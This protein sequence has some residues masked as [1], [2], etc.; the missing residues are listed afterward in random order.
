MLATLS[1]LL[2]T[3]V[4]SH[5]EGDFPF[6]KELEMGMNPE[7]LGEFLEGDIVQSPS[8]RNG[9][10][11]VTLRWEG[12]IVP[13]VIDSAHIGEGRKAIIEAME[14]YHRKTCIRLVN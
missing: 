12:G 4:S 5:P 9:V 10:L 11:N 1:F 2:L 7:E 6:E 13:F 3:A 14:E 8:T